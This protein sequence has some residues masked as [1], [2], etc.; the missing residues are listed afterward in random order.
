MFLDGD[1]L[2][3]PPPHPTVLPPGGLLFLDGGGKRVPV[4]LDEGPLLSPLSVLLAGGLPY[5]E[6]G[7][8]KITLTK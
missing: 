3:S 2:L 5:L 7:G 8:R 6:G 1:P 4:F